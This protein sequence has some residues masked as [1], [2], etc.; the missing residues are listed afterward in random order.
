[1]KIY[2]HLN[3][4]GFSNCY[5]IVN[6]EKKEAVIIDP[7]KITNQIIR[8]IEDDKYNLCAVLVTH[9]HGSHTRGLTTLRKIYNP[10]IYAADYETA[11]SDTNVL[12]G[13]GVIQAAGFTIGY[14]SVPGHSPDSMC[15]KIGKVI[16]TGDTLSAG[17]IGSTNNTYARSMLISNVQT[18]ILSQQDDITIMP[19]HGPPSSIA[20]EKQFNLDLGTPILRENIYK[21]LRYPQ[22]V[23]S[24]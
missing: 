3:L 11:G 20:A 6:P 12:K 13:N 18:K 23:I 14:M 21:T 16:F 22:R 1:M 4:E 2:F 19:G 7:G 17:K 10:K 15:Y 24:D 9:N 5:I 8:H